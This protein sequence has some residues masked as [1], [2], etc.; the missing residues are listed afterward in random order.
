MTTNMQE[1][2]VKPYS[3]GGFNACAISANGGTD[4]IAACLRLAES[5]PKP[6][7]DSAPSDLG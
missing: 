1:R 3:L 2:T 7:C 4:G 5:K 6:G